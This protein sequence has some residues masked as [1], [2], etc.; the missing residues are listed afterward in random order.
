MMVHYFGE[1]QDISD[2][3]IFCNKHNLFLIEDNAHGH[4]GTFN[5]HPL[6]SFGDI[7]IS[8][9]RKTLNIF[10]GGVLWLRNIALNPILELQ[11]YPVSFKQ[12]VKRKT[13]NPYPS[14]KNSIR[15]ILKNRPKFEDPWAFRE[16]EISDYSIDKWSKEIIEHTDWDEPRNTRQKSYRKWQE[17]SM[18]NGLNPVFKKLHSEVIPWCFPAYVKDQK[19][20]IRWFDWGWENN[21]NIFSWPT[22]PSKI[23][24]INGSALRRWQR[25]ICF[26]TEFNYKE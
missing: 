5:G 14:L 1:S 25:L 26:S 10:S 22:L 19:E 12:H 11:P 17:F 24:N 18:K 20:V 2:F 8:S 3:Q 7:G 16:R 6:G 15:K 13:L 9:P 4:G 23:I 21:V